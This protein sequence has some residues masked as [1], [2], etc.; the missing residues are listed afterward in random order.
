MCSVAENF[1]HWRGTITGQ[2][3]YIATIS[4]CYA[5]QQ[6]DAIQQKCFMAKWISNTISEIEQETRVCRMSAFVHSYLN[7]YSK[8]KVSKYHVNYRLA[9]TVHG[10][11]A[12]AKTRRLSCLPQLATLLTNKMFRTWRSNCNG[13]VFTC[14]YRHI[15]YFVCN[16]I[17]KSCSNPV[18]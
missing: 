18:L 7:A 12:D 2:D 11:A 9:A 1:C 13:C 10:L 16:G 17:S 8:G 15:S 3:R 6:I 5:M 14:L 4:L